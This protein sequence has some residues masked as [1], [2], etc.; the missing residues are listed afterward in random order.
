[1][2][3]VAG[4]DKK[5]VTVSYADCKGASISWA[6]CRTAGCNLKTCDGTAAGDGAFKCESTLDSVFEVPA[7]QTT[8][9]VQ[10]HDGRTAGDVACPATGPKGL[11]QPC[12]GGAGSSC[13]GAVSGVCNQEIDIRCTGAGCTDIGVCG[14]VP[15]PPSTP[16][17]TPAVTRECET[18]AQ[19]AVP[20][21]E[22]CRLMECT[23]EG[24][25]QGT[26]Q[27]A[28]D[29]VCRAA[30]T[31]CDNAETCGATAPA[32]P[33]AAFDCPADAWFQPATAYTATSYWTQVTKVGTA[34][35]SELNGYSYHQWAVTTLG[36]RECGAANPGNTN[37]K[38]GLCTG[39]KACTQPTQEQLREFYIVKAATD[40]Y[41]CGYFQWS[42]TAAIKDA[43]TG[44]N[45]VQAG[46]GWMNYYLPYP[47][48]L[49]DHY[50]TVKA[51]RTVT[52]DFTTKH[53][54]VQDPTFD[55]RAISHFQQG[56]LDLATGART[57]MSNIADPAGEVCPWWVRYSANLAADI[58]YAPTGNRRQQQQQRADDATLGAALKAD[59]AASLGVDAA[60]V[61]ITSLTRTV[62]AD[63]QSEHVV[64]S[65][66]VEGHVTGDAAQGTFTQT[67]TATGG[68]V[69]NV[70]VRPQQQEAA[71]PPQELCGVACLVA[72]SVAAVAVIIAAV[73]LT[74]LVLLRKRETRK[75]QVEVEPTAAHAC[76]VVGME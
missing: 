7:G 20:A 15:T 27:R 36:L 34:I 29:R 42:E 3:T 13:S 32:A 51:G 31:E 23:A 16:P 19:C 2:C 26:S 71:R 64:V 54:C 43:T 53:E 52:I 55:G 58:N 5:R 11:D 6:C 38:V 4:T 75:Q 40:T 47:E 68:T 28:A 66:S 59:I 46:D 48:C 14:A 9:T 8:I 73:S 21:N 12:C 45:H 56:Y 35:W 61:T 18:A 49:S 63:G 41:I 25:C 60:N 74:A 50:A 1:V 67:R 17:P 30:T 24:R 33:L 39:N 72:V 57:C 22:P 65:F 44:C 69:S 70:A 62:S 76:E 10:T 37:E